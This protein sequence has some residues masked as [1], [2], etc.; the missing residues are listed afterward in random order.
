MVNCVACAGP[1]VW[2]TPRSRYECTV[3]GLAFDASVSSKSYEEL[4]DLSEHLVTEHLANHSE[5]LTPPV[6]MPS[7]DVPKQREKLDD[8][9]LV[10]WNL[11][12]DD[13]EA[14]T[15]GRIG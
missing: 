15:D 1:A 14:T 13:S 12:F 9:P 3:C 6:W 7:Q 8:E 10:V 11:E 2:F 4:P 5:S